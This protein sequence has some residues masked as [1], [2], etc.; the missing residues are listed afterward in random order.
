MRQKLAGV[1]S[2]LATPFDEQGQLDQE[3]LRSLVRFQLDAGVHGFTILGI[4][5]EVSKLSEAERQRVTAAR[6]GSWP[7]RP[8]SAP[9][10]SSSRRRSGR[11][12]T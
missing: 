7:A 8:P 12:S 3:S 4:M 5:G 2:I 9:A 10:S 1:F 6:T 11:W